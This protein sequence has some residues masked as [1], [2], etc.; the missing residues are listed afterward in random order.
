MRLCDDDSEMVIS[1]TQRP[2][3]SRRT[4]KQQAGGER[5]N[6]GRT[7]GGERENRRSTHIHH[8]LREGQ[9]E[10]LANQQL[11]D[12]RSVSPSLHEENEACDW[13]RDLFTDSF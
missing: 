1:P 12:S 6:R 5:E 7:T 10:G 8:T 13:S 9:T 2:W 11:E 3:C 4:D